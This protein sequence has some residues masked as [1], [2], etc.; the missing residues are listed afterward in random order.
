MR[1]GRGFGNILL[2]NTMMLLGLAA[3]GAAG[4]GTAYKD[5]LCNLSNASTT[6][7]GH[8][9]EYVAADTDAD[10][11]AARTEEAK[12]FQKAVDEGKLQC[13]K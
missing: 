10:R 7:S 13:A 1:G 3:L 6:V 4:C 11:K 9:S 2:M 12:Q 8:Y 5:A